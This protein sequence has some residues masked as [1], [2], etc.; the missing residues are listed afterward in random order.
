MK[1]LAVI[2]DIHYAGA[3][4]RRR[5]SHE[6]AV[7]R[8][9]VLRLVVSAYR[10]YIWL[11]DPFAHNHLL[12]AVCE[13]IKDADLVVANGDFSCD[14][15]FVGLADDPSFASAQEATGIIRSRFA[16]RLKLT[17]GDHEL[18]KKS[19]F[20]GVGGLRL[21]S[22][23]RSVDQ[24]G[25]EPVWHLQ[26]GRYH[27]VGVTSSLWALPIFET[28]VLPS[29]QE[30][31]RE[32]RQLQQD[33]L[34]ACL[35]RIGSE[36]RWVLFCHDPTALPFLG[37]F[38]PVKSRLPQLERTVIGHLH[39]EL[40]LWKSRLLAG[41]PAI[42]FMGNS[43]RRMSRA[44]R[45]GAEWTPFRVTLCPSLAGLEIRKDGGFLFLDLDPSANRP[46]RIS[47]ESLPRS[48]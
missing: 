6:S 8:N 20:G 33:Q 40:I 24:L 39:S 47:R 3:A 41:M 1:R 5:V 28:D 30:A 36:D 9:P 29:E 14:S 15:A 31:W 37:G 22:W 18:G 38:P 11:R 42:D 45:S 32:L 27:L 17:M 13:R 34:A 48:A 10:H 12:P 25:I 35:E 16:N 46:L 44:L 43:I 21:A 7:I 19:L 4:E 23:S 26:F 2:S